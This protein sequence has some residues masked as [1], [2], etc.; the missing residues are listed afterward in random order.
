MSH[1]FRNQPFA[2][3]IVFFGDC[4]QA[5]A[6]ASAIMVFYARHCNLKQWTARVHKD[7]GV[8]KSWLPPGSS[9]VTHHLPNCHN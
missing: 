4:K 7:G 5:K 3:G 8:L 1:T 9:S 2:S 6:P